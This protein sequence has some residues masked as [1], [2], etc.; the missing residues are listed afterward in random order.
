MGALYVVFMIWIRVSNPLSSIRIVVK[1]ARRIGIVWLRIARESCHFAC[2]SLAP[3]QCYSE[4][5]QKMDLDLSYLIKR[6]LRVLMLC[7]G[8]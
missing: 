5:V 8:L 7:L 1:S 3:S 2:E 6:R 4:A